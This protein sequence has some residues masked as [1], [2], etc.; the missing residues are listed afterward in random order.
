MHLYLKRNQIYQKNQPQPLIFFSIFL[1]S[2][3]IDFTETILFQRSMPWRCISETNVILTSRLPRL[4]SNA[5]QFIGCMPK[6][7]DRQD[8]EAVVEN[9]TLINLHLYDF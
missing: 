8:F 6:L 9:Q 7:S 3:Q 1:L 5:E 4:Y 2:I